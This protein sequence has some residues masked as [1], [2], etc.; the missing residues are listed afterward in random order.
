M[1][2]MRMVEYSYH[3]ALKEE[4]KTDKESESGEHGKES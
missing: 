4:E 3:V 1:I 2:M